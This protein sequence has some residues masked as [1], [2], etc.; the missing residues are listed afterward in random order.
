LSAHL[1]IKD[2]LQPFGEL[3]SIDYSDELL[4]LAHDLGARLLAA[5]ENTATGIPHPRVSIVVAD[6]ILFLMQKCN[7]SLAKTNVHLIVL[8]NN[9]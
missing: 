3:S 8:H 2:P 4:H 1:I 9:Y 7:E 5:F 6:K